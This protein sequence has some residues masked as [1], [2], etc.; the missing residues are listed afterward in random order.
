MNKKLRLFQFI[1]LFLSSASMAQVTTTFNYTGSL[2]TYTVPPGVGNVQIEVR[3]AQGGNDGGFGAIMIGTFEVTPGEEL[4][5]LVGGAGETSGGIR[6]G[7]GGGSFVVN[8]MDEPLII[9]GGGGGRA[10]SGA[11]SPTWPG[12]DANITENG[13][14]G[15]SMEN[16]LGGSEERH[17]LGGSA[18]NGGGGAGP[19]GTPHAGNGGGFLTNGADGACGLGGQSFLAGG[20]G[21]TGCSGGPGGYG[22]GGNGGN[23]GGGGGGG[24][25]GGGGSYHNPTNG[26]G[27]GSYNAGTD[28]DNSVGNTGN[29]LVI[30]T[31]TCAPLTVTVSES[32]ICFGDEVTLSATSESGD[33][34]TWDMGV[35]DGVAFVPEMVGENIYTASTENDEDCDALVSIWVNELPVTYGAITPDDDGAGVGAIDLIVTG[36]AP[37]YTFDWNNDGTGDFDDTEDLTGLTSGVYVVV[38]KDANECESVAQSFYVSDLA[39]IADDQLLVD[40]YPNPTTA[41]INIQMQGSYLYEVY[42]LSGELVISGAGNDQEQVDVSDLSEGV[43]MLTITQGALKT[44]I[45]IAKN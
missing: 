16:G 31:E 26:G 10:W 22:G 42:T 12:I 13:N 25:S 33:E 37:T 39:G 5:I 21:G 38:A 27:G 11:G 29:G 28:Q 34:V 23:S 3:G 7:G 9:A 41:E 40:V 30:I 15:Y 44:Q 8:A 45:R 32:E 2:E 4:T 43:Y 14:D 6:S 17:G 36:G 19:D 20:A 35:E 1:L 18:G 24:Y